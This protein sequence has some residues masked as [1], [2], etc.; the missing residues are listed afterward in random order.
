MILLKYLNILA[1]Y[2][3]ENNYVGNSS[4]ISNVAKYLY[5][6]KISLNQYKFKSRPKSSIKI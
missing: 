4:M 2:R 3:C 6:K 5:T 1:R